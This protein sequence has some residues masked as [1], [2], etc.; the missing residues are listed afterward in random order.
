MTTKGETDP[1][2][3]IV[4][5]GSCLPKGVHDTHVSLLDEIPD[6]KGCVGPFVSRVTGIAKPHYVLFQRAIGGATRGF[7]KPWP[8]SPDFYPRSGHQFLSVPFPVTQ[9]LTSVP[10]GRTTTATET[11]QP[12]CHEYHNSI[13]RA[14]ASFL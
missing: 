4:R 11:S 6:V 7:C 13:H 8:E 2:P 14:Y 12:V 1:E 5:V 3:H 10:F 9:L